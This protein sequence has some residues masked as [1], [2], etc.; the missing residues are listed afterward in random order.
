LPAVSVL[1]VVIAAYL[2]VSGTIREDDTKEALAAVSALVALGGYLTHQWLKFQRQSLVYQ[3]E[4]SDNIYFRNINNNAGA[5]DY[6]VGS[7]EEQECKEAFL[8]Y[9]FLT[10]AATPLRQPE[11]ETRVERWLAD[12]FKVDVEFEVA[13]A[14]SKLARLKLLHRDGEA[15]AVLPLDE[16]LA[17]LERMWAGFFPVGAESNPTSS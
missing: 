2:G 7:A 9:C 13:E 4:I 3:K 5:L 6:I 10:T 1:F 11:L 12:T 8:A 15:L 16:A 14:L 17:A